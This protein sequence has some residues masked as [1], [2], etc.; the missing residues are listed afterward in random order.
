MEKTRR[1][2]IRSASVIGG[3]RVCI[4]QLSSQLCTVAH[5]DIQPSHPLSAVLVTM[6]KIACVRPHPYTKQSRWVAI[7]FQPRGQFLN[8]LAQYRIGRRAV[9]RGCAGGGGGQMRL[10]GVAPGIAVFF[11][12]RSHSGS[13]VGQGGPRAV[14]V[15]AGEAGIQPCSAAA[16]LPALLATANDVWAGGWRSSAY[17]SIWG[18][19]GVCRVGRGLGWRLLCRVFHP[20]L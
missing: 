7:D 11:P 19:P 17:H 3:R 15:A 6:A 10:E 13:G 8:P 4:L 18:I 14:L 5:D 16:H 1:R 2:T 9:V 12:N 20:L